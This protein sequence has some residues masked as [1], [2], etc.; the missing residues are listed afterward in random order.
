M[1]RPELK[2]EWNNY[3][4]QTQSQRKRYGEFSSA[5]F[6]AILSMSCG[7]VSL[8]IRK[9]TYCLSCS[10]LA[11]FSYKFPCT[12]KFIGFFFSARCTAAA[13]AERSWTPHCVR[14]I[15]CVQREFIEVEV[16][17]ELRGIWRQKLTLSWRHLETLEKDLTNSDYSSELCHRENKNIQHRIHAATDCTK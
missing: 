13:P 17:R 2:E 9:R 5:D 15:I 12:D 1:S 7:A 16:C 10:R 11:G 8:Q 14:E 3:S 6:I 4:C